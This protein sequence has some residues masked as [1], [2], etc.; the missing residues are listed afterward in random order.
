MAA[1][2]AVEPTPMML[3]RI[4][5]VLVMHALVR[6][7]E[8]KL[9]FDEDAANKG[10]AVAFDVVGKAYE[11]LR[12]AMRELDDFYVREGKPGNAG[13][14]DAMRPLFKKADGVLK[15][16]LATQASKGKKQKRTRKPKCRV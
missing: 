1:D 4:S 14:A 16:A 15:E 9:G 2:R 10:N 8:A 6:R 3:L 7:A 11:R 5:D 13:I 12:K